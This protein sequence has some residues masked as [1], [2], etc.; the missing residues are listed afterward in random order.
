MPWVSGE[1]QGA[2][3][4]DGPHRP[5]LP[6]GLTTRPLGLESSLRG[7]ISWPFV[8]CTNASL[9]VVFCSPSELSCVR[10]NTTPI[11][12]S[13][14]PTLRRL[15][16]SVF[17]LPI[18][19]ADARRKVKVSPYD[20]PTPQRAEELAHQGTSLSLHGPQN[21]TPFRCDGVQ[22]FYFPSSF[23]HVHFKQRSSKYNESYPVAGIPRLCSFVCSP[24]E[25][26][27]PGMCSCMCLGTRGAETVASSGYTL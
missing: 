19:L 22:F 6:A 16:L 17:C 8:V 21:L 15:P 20:P 10:G 25:S 3:A 24:W 18:G 27:S 23:V 11:L 9:S 2:E 1:D 26:Q 5:W 4:C 7:A 12:I 14:H 13:E